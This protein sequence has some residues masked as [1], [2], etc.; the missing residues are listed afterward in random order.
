MIKVFTAQLLPNA[1]VVKAMLE[2]QQIPCLLKNEHL[3][4]AIGEIPLVECWPEVWVIHDYQA[5]RA[6]ELIH[7]YM[8]TS[9]NADEAPWRCPEC[10]EQVDAIFARCW[11]C[12]AVRD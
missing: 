4:I 1:S 3:S 8:T 7:D 11:N 9:P 6:R 5:E 10:A 12:L 2:S